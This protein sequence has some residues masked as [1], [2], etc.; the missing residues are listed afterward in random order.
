MMKI[1]PDTTK[2]E[3]GE[4]HQHLRAY[5]TYLSIKALQKVGAP[6]Q[7]DAIRD[8]NQQGPL[9]V[10]LAIELGTMI[11]S[12]LGK[13]LGGK[14]IAEARERYIEKQTYNRCWYIVK[15]RELDV[16]QR[17]ITDI[18]YEGDRLEG[19]LLGRK[20]AER[21]EC[22]NATAETI[23]CI[24]RG[25][26]LRYKKKPLSKKRFR[27]EKSEEADNWSDWLEFKELSR[28]FEEVTTAFDKLAAALKYCRAEVTEQKGFE[29]DFKAQLK[30]IGI[31]DKEA[32][33]R[34]D[35]FRYDDIRAFP[36]TKLLHNWDN[37]WWNVFTSSVNNEINK[38]I[39][40]NSHL[41]LM[42]R[43]AFLIQEARVL[44]EKN[45]TNYRGEL[46]SVI[47]ISKEI[48]PLKWREE[49]RF[50]VSEKSDEYDQD[51][52]NNAVRTAL[53]TLRKEDKEARAWLSEEGGIF[54]PYNFY[55]K[56]IN[57]VRFTRMR[58]AFRQY[59]M[60]QASN[61][62]YWCLSEFN[63]AL[64]FPALVSGYSVDTW[65][66]WKHAAISGNISFWC[67]KTNLEYDLDDNNPRCSAT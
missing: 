14:A 52:Q 38:D 44:S 59:P 41:Q 33:L 7:I 29:A 45:N 26:F 57:P 34:F 50:K 46:Y 9:K 19:N 22:A 13:N 24:F 43:D 60:E 2:I 30:R 56:D 6:T 37:E 65:N 10:T 62:L 47:G 49:S 20:I 63:Q 4:Y 51:K 28:S 5:T 67:R 16:L 32:R 17:K 23:K 54:H 64:F 61:E 48:S 35:L 25:G 53:V 15:K 40:K 1:P 8:P 66:A 27:E 36:A 31:L 55:D 39:R 12:V 3:E 42:L 58:K 18:R 11:L 21:V